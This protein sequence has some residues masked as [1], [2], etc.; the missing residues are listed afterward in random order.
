MKILFFLAFLQFLC[1]TCILVYFTYF[2]N[3]VI[4]A[5]YIWFVLYA[6]YKLTSVTLTTIPEK[7]QEFYREIKSFLFYSELWKKTMNSQCTAGNLLDIKCHK[8]IQ[9]N[10]YKT[11]TLGTTQEWLSWESGCLL[12]KTT[13]NHMWSFLARS[14]FFS[15]G[16]VCLNKDLQL[17]VLVPLLKIKNVLSYFSFWMYIY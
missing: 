12:Y 2:F 5:K 16:N 1:C 13:T 10:L 11:T 17:R 14:P 7:D 6:S 15:H 8:L 9:S 4:Y 3:I